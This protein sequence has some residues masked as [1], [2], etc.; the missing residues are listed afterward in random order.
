MSTPTRMTL[1]VL[2]LALCG[3]EA[4]ETPSPDPTPEGRTVSAAEREAAQVLS[5]SGG[6]PAESDDPYAAALACEAAVALL[7][8]RLGE[9]EVVGAQ[10]KKAFAQVRQI[11]AGRIRS[12]APTGMDEQ[13]IE[14]AI[15]D[16]RTA[17]KRQSA[18]AARTGLSCIKALEAEA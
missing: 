15:S 13:E 5:L 10:E 17:A 1:V 18:S 4:A 14:L 6:A 3:C 12:S 9:T 7:E 11:Y 8:D 2:A 16:A